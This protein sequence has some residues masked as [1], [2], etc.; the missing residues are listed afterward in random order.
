M[1]QRM[2]DVY[3]EYSLCCSCVVKW[4][5]IFFEGRE[6]LEVDAPPGQA[7]RVITP[8]M[9]ARLNALVLENHRIIVNEIHQLLG[10]SMGTTLTIMHQHCKFRKI[11]TQW[12]PHQLTVQQN[13]TRMGLSLSHLKRY[14]VEEYTVFRPFT[15]LVL[16]F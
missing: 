8:K 10:I 16:P 5:K 12:V 1:N 9:I 3:V 7:H 14:H 6:L 2:K 13:N 11:C 4:C 15:V